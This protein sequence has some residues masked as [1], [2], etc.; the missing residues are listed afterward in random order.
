MLS[1][2]S[3]ISY[4]EDAHKRYFTFFNRS[5]GLFKTAVDLSTCTGARVVIIIESNT[6]KVSAFGTPSVDSTIDSF[7][8]GSVP[9]NTSVNEQSTDIVSLQNKLFE[10]EKWKAVDNERKKES[11]SHAKRFQE[12]SSMG[13][14]IYGNIEDL[15][16]DEVHELL[17]ELYLVQQEIED[18]NVALHPSYQLKIGG[19]TKPSAP[20]QSSLLLTGLSNSQPLSL[21]PQ[22]SNPTMLPSS[23]Q[24]QEIPYLQHILMLQRNSMEQAPLM[25]QPN[26]SHLQN[27]R[28]WDMSISGSA[29]I[30]QPFSQS[31]V[32]SSPQIPFSIE[33]SP[34]TPSPQITLLHDANISLEGQNFNLFEPS[35]NHGKTHSIVNS[36]E[37]SHFFGSIDGNNFSPTQTTA[38]DQ[39]PSVT[40]TN[41]PY[42]DSLLGVDVQEEYMGD[43]GGQAAN[44]GF[45]F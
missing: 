22:S 1:R 19:H 30:S 6:G 31:S 11:H 41:E 9:M 13:K 21:T 20:R 15:G 42:Y 37:L 23:A 35:Q 14:L 26:E 8:L 5:N 25:P 29:N 40:T 28:I 16:V 39:W 17:H 12:R 24:P 2:T 18:R 3:G 32:P 27:Y 10:L 34:Q 36:D 45:F 33:F 43:I 38:N 7:L 4:V 44:N